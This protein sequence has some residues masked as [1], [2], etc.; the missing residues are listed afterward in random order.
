MQGLATRTV[1]EWA[2][3]NG[4]HRPLMMK[5]VLKNIPPS[6]NPLRS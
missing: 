6:K 3:T 5:N 4:K 1:P 2:R